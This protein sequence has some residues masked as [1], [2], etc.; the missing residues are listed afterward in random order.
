MRITV[1]RFLAIALLASTVFLPLSAHAQTAPQ[2]SS[3][4]LFFTND[5]IGRIETLAAKTPAVEPAAE[6]NTVTLGAI[7]YAG[8]NDWTV[9]LQGKR[10]TPATNN[11]H[12]R[13]TNVQHDKVQL[14][15]APW[16]SGTA[17]D[18]TLRPFESY[19]P[20]TGEIRQTTQQNQ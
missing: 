19:S 20:L 10:W 17:R 7:V 15:V 3:P 12:L 9:W 2:A 13:I 1:S 11:P 5:E 16:G 6:Q 8:P 18:I 4:S 14:I